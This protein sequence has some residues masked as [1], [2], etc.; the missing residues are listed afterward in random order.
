MSNAAI[1]AAIGEAAEE[2]LKHTET[3]TEEPVEPSETEE[4]EESEEVE[5]EGEPDESLDEQEARESILLYKALK[6]PNQ[7]NAVIAALAQQAGILNQPLETRKEA[8]GAKNEILEIFQESLGKEYSFLA[9][10]LGKAVERVLERERTERTA[11]F[12]QIEADKI[13]NETNVALDKLARDTKGDSRRLENQMSS[14]ME[15][16]PPGPNTGVEE[17]I[18]GIYAMASRAGVA[19]Q[20]ENRIADKI[21]RNAN[22]AAGRLHTTQSTEPKGIPNRKMSIKESVDWALKELESGRC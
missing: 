18:R 22:D 4:H 16:F 5:T 14:L 3:P 19:K 2:I 9:D 12:Q 6:D 17:Y 7:R 1:D 15:K 11:Q 13:I 8:E 20:T 10:R 21:R